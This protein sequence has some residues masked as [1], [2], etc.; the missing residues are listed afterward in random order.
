MWE[1]NKTEKEPL[2]HYIRWGA[3]KILPCLEVRDLILPEGTPFFFVIP[4]MNI[5][6]GLIT[7]ELTRLFFFFFFFNVVDF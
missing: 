2:I 7:N 3:I 6:V 4:Y 1:G 5:I